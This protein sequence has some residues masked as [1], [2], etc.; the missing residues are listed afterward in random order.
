MLPDP[1]APEPSAAPS[2]CSSVSVPA[3]GGGDPASAASVTG[4]AD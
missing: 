3:P 1:A 2:V 4:S